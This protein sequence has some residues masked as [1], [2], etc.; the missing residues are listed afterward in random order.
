MSGAYVEA[1]ALIYST[2]IDLRLSGGVGAA[3][4]EKYGTEIQDK[5]FNTIDD[6]GRQIAKVGEVFECSISTMP[7]EIV[8]HTVATNNIYET[9][10]ETVRDILDYCLN[11]CI[12]NGNIKSVVT[13]AL[14]CGWGDLSHSEFIDIS[15]LVTKEIVT[16]TII[17]FTVCCDNQN[18]Y[19]Q[20]CQSASKYKNDWEFG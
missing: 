12:E 1:D 18:F 13:S 7:W 2:N 6:T 15:N 16:D 9:K 11:I 3:L 19:K 5:L 14:G 20:L 4:L 8:F 17:D 10:A